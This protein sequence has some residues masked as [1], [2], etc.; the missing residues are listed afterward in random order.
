MQLSLQRSLYKKKRGKP[1]TCC[2]CGSDGG[3]NT[4]HRILLAVPESTIKKFSAL[5]DLCVSSLRRGHANLLCVVPILTDDPRRESVRESGPSARL[6]RP[7]AAAI[8]GNVVGGREGA[9][10][11][12]TGGGALFAC[13]L[14]ASKQTKHRPVRRG[15]EREK[16]DFWGVGGVPRRV[17]PRLFPSSSPLPSRACLA[18]VSRFLVAPQALFF[19]LPRGAPQSSTKF[20]SLQSLRHGQQASPQDEHKKQQTQDPQAS[21]FSLAFFSSPPLLSPLTTGDLRSVSNQTAFLH[22]Q[23][24][25]SIIDPPLPFAVAT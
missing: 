25:G 8:V 3:C 1:Q 20:V 19:F 11:G 17:T 2:S 21:L 6:V 4:P 18:P 14:A 23:I 24:W 22:R 9:E 10:P 12:K 13:L 15:A 16:N 5:P 7:A